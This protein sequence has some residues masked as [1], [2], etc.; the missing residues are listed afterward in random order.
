VT[1]V[2]AQA[3]FNEVLNTLPG[4]PAPKLALA[5][6]DEL[7]LQHQGMNTTR[8]L[9]SNV[10]KAALALTYTQGAQQ[11]PDYS[12]VPG[13]TH[14]SQ[15]PVALRFHTIRLYGLVWAT[16]ASTVS[17]AFG[18][19][20]QL[21]AEGLV[22]AAVAALD[23]LPQSSR[24]HRMARLTTVLM[25]I[26]EKSSLNE[27]RLRRAARRLEILPT[28]EPRIP[29]VRLAVLAA[30]LE[31]L[32]AEQ[33]KSGGPGPGGEGPVVRRG[34]QRARDCAPVLSRGSATSPASPLSPATGSGWWTWP[35]GSGPGPGSDPVQSVSLVTGVADYISDSSFAARA[36]ASSS[37]V[38]TTSTFTAE[39]S[40]EITRGPSTPSSL[41]LRDVVDDDA[42]VLQVSHRVAADAHV[43][44]ADAG[45]E[46]HCVE[47]AQL[48][49]ERADV[50]ADT[51]HV[52]VVGLLRVLVALVDELLN[53]AEVVGP[54]QPLQA[55]A[56]VEQGVDLV[57][58]HL[59][60]AVEVEDD[61]GVDVAG[62]RAHDQA[63]QRG[64]AHGGVDGPAATDGGH[65]GTVAQVQGDLVDVV[66]VLAQDLRDQVGDVLVAGAVEAVAPDVVLVGDLTVEAVPGRRLRQA[67][68]E[69]RVEHGDVL[70][71]GQQRP[72]V[73]DAVDV[74]GVVQGRQ[75]IRVNGCR[76]RSR[77]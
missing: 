38:G 31:W 42:E 9:D 62:T 74:G 29:Q 3:C 71:V 64:Q 45:G 10:Q 27:A 30:A 46:H 51:V 75:G 69:G 34:V 2:A 50:P 41:L 54:G 65:R 22:D 56:L 39:S 17:A 25:L 1:I 23:R 11:S 49:H 32:R 67:V 68:E 44:L 14:L 33:E 36:I 21:H 66:G 57:D 8:L 48:Q 5:A 43:V 52:D 35:T 59:A 76:R 53:Q 13:W 63:L 19:A 24:H 16:N 28:N 72:G 77:R 26:T 61:A 7:M 60:L 55:G 20:R 15:D 47:T 12:E 37:F 18:L 58:G 4:E 40:E 70:D 6:T 73:L